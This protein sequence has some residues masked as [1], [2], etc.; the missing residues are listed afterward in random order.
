M[1]KSLWIAV[2]FG[3][4]LL[5]LSVF[6]VKQGISASLAREGVTLNKLKNIN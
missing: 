3:L 2:F 1:S 5:A 6:A 4:G